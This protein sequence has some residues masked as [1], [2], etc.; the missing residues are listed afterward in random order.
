MS[1]SVAVQ[2]D[3]LERINI[4][5]DSTF[6][7]MLKAQELGHTLYHYAPEHL[8]FTEGRLWTMGYPVKV[9]RVEGDHYSFAEPRILD[10]G[11]DVDVVLMRQDPPFDLGYITATH[12]LEKIQGET[13]VVNDP[14]A[15]RDAPEKVWVLDLPQFMPPTAITR[16]KG[17]T[18]KFLAEH[19]EIVI[20]PLH[21]FAGGSVFRIGP[22]G[23]NLASLI[24]LFNKS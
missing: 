4:G 18:R 20:K 3:P 6:A 12:L 7:I 23:R 19:G 17:L 21:G 8:S 22:D 2:M 15:V 14:A 5:G 1:L 16:S 13:L 11:K 9:Q 24:E 10:L